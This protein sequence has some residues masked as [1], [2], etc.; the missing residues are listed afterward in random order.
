[1]AT[2]LASI[3]SDVFTGEI[4]PP[5]EPLFANLQVLSGTMKT[6]GSA[7]VPTSGSMLAEQGLATLTEG[8]FVE[9]R[10][11]DV[12]TPPSIDHSERRVTLQAFEGTV[13]SV[14][15]DEFD[16]VLFDLTDRIRP[17]EVVSFSLQEVSEQDRELIS[18]GN[19]FYWFIGY[20]VS[21]SGQLTRTS[22]IRFRRLPAWTASR[23][24]SLR[25][26]ATEQFADLFK[27]A[28]A[29]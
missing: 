19:V 5:K 28:D 13:Q 1:M 12:V 16:A 20:D 21:R 6:D 15:G 7:D 2:A 9:R 17:E 3:S 18:Q 24:R 4:P 10:T 14:R 27:A 26:R 22:R 11:R 29:I 25:A 8:A 23:L